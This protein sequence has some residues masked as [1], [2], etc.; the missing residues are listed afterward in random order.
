MKYIKIVLLPISVAEG[1]YCWGNNRI[2]T[3]FDN[4]GGYAVC[5][6]QLGSE[7]LRH[8]NNGHYP[9]PEFCRTLKEKK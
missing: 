8:D 4:E 3:H 7:D 6:L 5:L 2:C 9:K 1:D